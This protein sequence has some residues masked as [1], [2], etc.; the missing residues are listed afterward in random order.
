MIVYVETNY[1]F[2]LGLGRAQQESCR[3]LV[4]WC[5]AG[6]I[7][8]RLPAFAIPEMHSA[9]RRRDGDRLDVIRGLKS[10]QGDARRHSAD[11]S[12]YAIAEEGLRAWT[13]REGDQL[14]ALAL[15]LFRVATFLPLDFEAL[16][17]TYRLR[18]LKVLTGDADLFI[19]A[20]II[21][22]L[23]VRKSQGDTS[24]SLFVTGDAD[25]ANAKTYLQP[26][27]CDLLTSY[28]AAV[29]RLKAELA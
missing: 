11:P 7:G 16:E 15:D 1:L 5:R 4:N 26:Y 27:S 20:S 22:D 9:V 2:E 18:S 29:G 21:R 13:L 14:K 17:I 12:T 23:D 3:V 6:R 25:F 10:Q 19:L 8:L 28:S 24:P